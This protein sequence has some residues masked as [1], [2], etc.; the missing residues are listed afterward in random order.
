MK[1]GRLSPT[2]P[3]MQQQH[4]PPRVQP[5][6]KCCTGC[7]SLSSCKLMNQG[8]AQDR[9]SPIEHRKEQRSYSDASLREAFS[10]RHMNIF[11]GAPTERIKIRVS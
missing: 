8:L 1:E 5:C 7:S 6:A 2:A 4:S 9:H 11:A 10:N 3:R